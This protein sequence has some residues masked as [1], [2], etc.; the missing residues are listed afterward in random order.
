VAVVV[1]LLIV[2]V[3]FAITDVFC[4]VL[5]GSDVEGTA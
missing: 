1:R 5:V 4:G 2:A 3:F